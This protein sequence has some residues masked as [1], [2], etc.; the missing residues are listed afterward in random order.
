MLYENDEK[1]NEILLKEKNRKVQHSLKF[2]DV[3]QDSYSNC[4]SKYFNDGK[5]IYPF[6]LVKSKIFGNRLI[7]VPF[8]DVGGFL[9]KED[10]KVLDELKKRYS[11]IE[12]RLNKFLEN[13]EEQEKILLKKGFSKIPSKHQFIIGLSSEEEMWKNFHKHTRNDIRKAEKSNLKIKKISGEEIKKFYKLYLQEMKNFGTPQHSKKFFNNLFEKMKENVYGL[14]CYY[15]NK[16]IGSIIIVFRGKYGYVMFNVSDRKYRDFRPN[17]LLYWETIKWAI[18]KKIKFIDVGQVDEDA[19]KGTH[20]YGLYKFKNKWLGK[21]YERVYFTIPKSEEK[22]KKEK[23]K[24]FR[25]IWSKMPMFL[26]K[27]IGPRITRE[28]GI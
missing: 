26:I 5:S 27:I 7:S 4:V 18:D 6:F 3:I 2:R 21:V 12:V 11:K 24:K 15:G 1:W 25:K 14:N 10:G 13:Y 17:D 19:E 20:A 23:L 8:L 16:L 22:E 9:G 28:M